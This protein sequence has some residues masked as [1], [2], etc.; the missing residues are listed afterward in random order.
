MRPSLLT[1]LI[2]CLNQ[3]FG[4]SP[5]PDSASVTAAI[6]RYHHYMG[7]QARIYNGIEFIPYDPSMK[8]NAF[9]LSDSLNDASILYDGV[10]YER[11]PALYDIIADKLVIADAN[12]NLL[13]PFSKKVEHFFLR[14]HDFIQTSKGYYDVLCSGAFS[15]RV[16]RT[17]GIEEFMSVQEYTRTATENDHFYLVK[18]DVYYPL[19]NVFSLLSQMGDKKKAVRQYLRKN[20]IRMRKDKEEAIVKAAEYYN[21]LSH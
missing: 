20:K 1:V 19:G 5:M 13:C 9:F 2:L 8:G 21:Q 7:T 10:W 17:K 16:K 18:N 6:N 11:I 3:A 15:I 4:Q 14:G 12:G